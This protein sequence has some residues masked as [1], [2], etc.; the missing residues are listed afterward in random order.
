[1]TEPVS[2]GGMVGPPTNFGVRRIGVESDPSYHALGPDAVSTA[3]L[4]AAL[5]T[6]SGYTLEMVDSTETQVAQIGTSS[7]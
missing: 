1:M 2:Q 4:M 6:R 3:I 7:N 5:Y